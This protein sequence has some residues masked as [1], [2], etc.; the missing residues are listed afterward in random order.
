MNLRRCAE[1]TFYFGFGILVPVIMCAFILGKLR[2]VFLITAIV[3]VLLHLSILLRRSP[4]RLMKLTA[5]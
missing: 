1:Y 3:V 2:L 5:Q 4:E